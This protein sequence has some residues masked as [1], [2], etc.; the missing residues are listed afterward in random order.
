MNTIVIR[1]TF[2]ANEEFCYSEGKHIE[3][4]KSYNPVNQRKY[5]ETICAFLNS[6][7]GYLLF[8]IDDNRIMCGM[9]KKHI[10]DIGLM[11]DSCYTTLITTSGEEL[12]LECITTRIIISSCDKLC[13]VVIKCEKTHN[14]YQFQN[15]NTY[16][17][18]NASNFHY[19]GIVYRRESQMR[20]VYET[21]IKAMQTHYL[22]E[23]ADHEEKIAELERRHSEE[24][25]YY[26]QFMVIFENE[27][28][29]HQKYKQ[30]VIFLTFML[31]IIMIGFNVIYL[32]C[33]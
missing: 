7:G 17:R 24:I 2:S 33:K 29:R 18:N 11:A 3:F 27:A 10:D 8:G 4:K 21:N 28:E 12:P 16:Y 5:C 14:L 13:I 22:Q 20:E 6:Q 32:S 30:H 9:T 25:A 31:F 15:G 23:V 19:S 26:K 1:D